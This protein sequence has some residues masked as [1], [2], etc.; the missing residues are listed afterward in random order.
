MKYFGLRYVLPFLLVIGIWVLW[1]N[2]YYGDAF[3]RYQST[4]EIVVVSIF[5]IGIMAQEFI[6]W[7]INKL[8]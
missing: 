5:S 1:R 6:I 7:V 3:I 8:K 4:I 2:H